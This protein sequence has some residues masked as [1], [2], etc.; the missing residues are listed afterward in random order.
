MRRGDPNKQSNGEETVLYSNLPASILSKGL[1]K[2]ED[3]K[4]T[5][6]P[7]SQWGTRLLLFWV[8]VGAVLSV[9]V[10]PNVPAISISSNFNQK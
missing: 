7:V 9:D 10:L 2:W 1:R 3:F 6:L 8:G 4:F 5:V